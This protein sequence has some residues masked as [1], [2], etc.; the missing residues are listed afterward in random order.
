MARLGA[1]LANR[2]KHCS[3]QS[4]YRTTVFSEKREFD[5]LVECFFFPE[6]PP[7]TTDE[8]K[9]KLDDKN[10]AASANEAFV[11]AVA[12]AFHGGIFDRR[13]DS[14]N[15]DR[16]QYFAAAIA[17]SQYVIRHMSKAKRI[18]GALD[19]LQFAV[20]NMT[21]DGLVLEFGVFS[22]RTINHI[23]RL[24]PAQRIYGFDSFKGLPEEWRP[25]FGKGVFALPAL[26]TVLNNVDLV[27]G[28]FDRTLPSFLDKNADQEVALLHVDCDIYSSTQ[29]IF[30]HL[31]F[32]IVPGTIIVFDEYYNYPGWEMNEFRAFQEFIK[33][34]GLN[35]DYIGL[36]PGHQQ[37]AVRI[38]G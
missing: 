29:S 3:K 30:H 19:L 38:V 31:K 1:I 6:G 11:E 22:G 24:L 37:V 16:L 17:S 5:R 21:L 12:P 7:M 32:R 28:W 34:T 25:G 26:P 13:F 20:E 8:T 27:V 23:A 33:T 9:A 4:Y 18:D 36:V 10:S 35:Y 2:E 15:V 14:Y